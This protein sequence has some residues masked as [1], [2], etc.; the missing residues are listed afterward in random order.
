M[1][2]IARSYTLLTRLA[3]CRIFNRIDSQAGLDKRNSGLWKLACCLKPNSLF[4][5]SVRRLEGCSI[6]SI[7]N[8]KADGGLLQE[9]QELVNY[10]KG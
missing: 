7:T 10:L 2:M 1:K 9:F 8:G 6:D 4:C 5:Y 3:R